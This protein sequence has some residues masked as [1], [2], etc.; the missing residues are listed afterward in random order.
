[1]PDPVRTPDASSVQRGVM[2]QYVGTKDRKHACALLLL[3]AVNFILRA[4]VA[5]RP[6]AAIDGLTIPDDAYLSLHLAR[7]IAHGLGPFYG[8]AFTNGFQPLYVFLCVP[9][10]WISTVDLIFPVHYALLLLSVV[11]TL[12]L[13]LLIRIIRR[14]SRHPAVPFI[15]GV[16]WMFSQY[17]LRTTMNGLETM[18][19]VCTA[20]A[21]LLYYQRQFS[22][23]PV[24]PLLRH[25]SVLGL[26]AGLSI[27]ARIDNA[28]LVAVLV[29]WL[30]PGVVRTRDVKPFL[31]FG[32]SALMAIAPWL[33]YSGV[34][35]GS[36]YPVSG[37]A[38]RYLALTGAREAPSLAGW[39]I[40]Q[41][42]WASFVVAR[43][44]WRL[45]AVLVLVV[46][47]LAVRKP[48]PQK[49]LDVGRVVAPLGLFALVL[50]VVY[51][52]YAPASWF[53]VRYLFPSFP[54]F[55][56]L[57]ALL[58]D[59]ILT[60]FRDRPLARKVGIG[61][62]LVL[63]AFLASDPKWTEMYASPPHPH[64]GYRAIGVW[65]R[66]SLPPGSIIGA[67]QSGGIGYFATNMT[68][69]N[70]DGVVNRECLDSIRAFSI[71]EYM[72]GN[73][74][75][76]II[77]WLGNFRFITLQAK[78]RNRSRIVMGHPIDSI[79]SWNSP[80][81]LGRLLPGES[82]VTASRD[83]RDSARTMRSE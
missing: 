23:K 28:F 78:D 61:V 1:M 59:V 68:V 21:L 25:W 45:I 10:F 14:E 67:P 4:V 12:A 73:S 24:P 33:I 5:L 63:S 64:D 37:T 51:P 60:D 47:L 22:V 48:A 39:Y 13:Y 56:I 49:L 74:V 70:L 32:F 79:R 54:V 76:Y 36:L 34:Y 41:L 3:L 44:N 65:A 30:L 80:W 9:A 57:I 82:G 19:A 46:I 16:L 53:Y 35:T 58:F 77:G 66:D 18:L 15:A 38:V 29:L 72:E 62:I 42:G 55:V 11:D 40:V 6:L 75:Q 26:L 8:K 71:V 7:S 20:L 43:E 83:S 31:V 27:L 17:P 2:V 50:M 69:L 81:F 52:F